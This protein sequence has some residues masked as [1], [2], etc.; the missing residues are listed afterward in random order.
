MAAAAIAGPLRT[1]AQGRPRRGGAAEFQEAG[2]NQRLRTEPS[3]ETQLSRSRGCPMR[4]RNARLLTF[5]MKSKYTH[6]FMPQAR[7]QLPP[8]HGS[9]SPLARRRVTLRFSACIIIYV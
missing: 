5:V 6:F 3:V 9:A 1:L 7:P 2:L 4:V 8:L